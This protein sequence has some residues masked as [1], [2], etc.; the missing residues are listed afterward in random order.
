M[1][2]TAVCVILV[3]QLP[4]SLQHGGQT[5]ATCSIQQCRYDVTLTCSVDS[6]GKALTARSV[7]VD[8]SKKEISI[9]QSPH[10]VSVFSITSPPVP[11]YFLGICYD[12]DDV[13]TEFAT[14]FPLLIL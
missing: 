5:S 8:E 14:S 9:L 6:F 3:Q 10:T 11:G 13:I 1:F 2:I 4:T 7:I 12:D